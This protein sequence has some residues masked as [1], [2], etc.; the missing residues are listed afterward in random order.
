MRERLIRLLSR[1]FNIGDSYTFNLTRVKTAFDV[2][3]IGLDD[4]EE[5]TEDDVANLADYLLDNGVI[6]P[7]VKV[8]T[9]HNKLSFIAV[10][11]LK[12]KQRKRPYYILRCDC[13]TITS[14]RR[15]L[16]ISGEVKS[17]GCLYH[18]HGQAKGNHTRIYDI[19]HGMKKRCYNPNSQGYRYYGARGIKICEEWQTFEAFYKWAMENG[20]ADNLTID[21]IDVNGNYEPSNCRWVAWEVQRINTT[22]ITPVRIIETGKV[23]KSVADCARFLNGSG[24]NISNCINGKLD[25]YKGYHFEKITKEAAEVALKAREKQ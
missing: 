24:G 6:L 16:W 5:Y 15:D 11:E 17:C 19:Y 14:V 13:G 2:G 4:F 7:P 3:T 25:S 10:D 22:R 8:G 23:F 12:S 9:K 18:K 1:Y 20:Y 21:R